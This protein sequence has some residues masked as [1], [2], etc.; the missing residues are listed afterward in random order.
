M[1][2]RLNNADVVPELPGKTLV[3]RSRRPEY[4]AVLDPA[5][6]PRTTVF[7]TTGVFEGSGR[8]EHYR[9]RIVNFRL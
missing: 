6:N 8:A 2:A 5:V 1:S 7:G 9:R 3:A 4:F